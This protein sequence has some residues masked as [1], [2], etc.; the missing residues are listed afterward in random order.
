MKNSELKRRK[1][2]P[3]ESTLMPTLPIPLSSFP[4][5]FLNLYAFFFYIFYSPTSTNY[6]NLHSFFD[7]LNPF[8]HLNCPFASGCAA[9][10]DSIVAFLVEK[11]KILLRPLIHTLLHFLLTETHSCPLANI[12]PSCIPLVS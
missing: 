10:L 8:F 9:V 1:D 5:C 3:K 4:T 11:R 2:C 7:H 6:S 12:L